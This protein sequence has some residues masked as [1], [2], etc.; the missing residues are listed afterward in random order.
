M[1]CAFARYNINDKKKK[2]TIFFNK[3]VL[4][5]YEIAEN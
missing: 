1:L 3:L 4:D 5:R 2:K